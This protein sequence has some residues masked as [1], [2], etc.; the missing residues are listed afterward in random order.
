MTHL[1][2]LQVGSY[3]FPLSDQVSIG[4]YLARAIPSLLVLG[5]LGEGGDTHWWGIWRNASRRGSLVSHLIYDGEL[6]VKLVPLGDGHL[7]KLEGEARLRKERRG[8]V[9][10]PIAPGLPRGPEVAIET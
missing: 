2:L 8:S 5:L 9:L 1:Q 6:D 7:A 3:I 10:S 4:M